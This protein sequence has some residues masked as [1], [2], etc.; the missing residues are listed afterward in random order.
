MPVGPRPRKHEIAVH[1]GTQSHGSAPPPEAPF[2]VVLLGDFSGRANRGV[3]EVGA[4]LGQRRIVQVDRDTLDDVLAKLAPELRLTL[5]D[6]SGAPMALRFR[7]LDDF[8]PDRLYDTVPLFQA[9]RRARARVADADAFA[10]ATRS[11]RRAARPDDAGTAVSA[12]TAREVL[13]APGALLDKILDVSA[14]GRGDDRTVEPD[15][16]Q[17]LVRRLVAPHVVPG[18]DPRQAEWLERV[19]AAIGAQMRSILHHPD[20]Q[21]L[22]ALWRAVD[23]LT[24]RIETS[25][26]LGLYVIDVSRAEVAADLGS[27][28]PLEATGLYRLLV[29]RSV[30]TAGGRPWAVVV[31]AYA[32]GPGS[33]D[34]QLLGALAAL[35]RAAGAPWI[36][37]AADGLAGCDSLQATP[38]PA[39]W[40]GDVDPA[41]DAL[42]RSPNAMWLGLMLPR[43]LLRLPYGADT[44][45]CDAIAF[46]E[47]AG[48]PDP[49]Q[50]LWGNPAVAA[51]LL[52]S[53]AFATAGW[54][55]RPG[56]GLDISHLPLHVVR[57]DGEVVAQPCAEVLL[58]ERAAQRLLD[59]GLM[60]LAS[61]KDTDRARLV[62]FQSV[63]SP[64]AAL[65][66]RW[67]PA[68]PES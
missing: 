17:A 45:P 28:Q 13:G 32:F 39:D 47:F 66:G 30:G 2:S 42:R 27:G 41:F 35:A 1:V 33:E 8:H 19:D 5:P 40:T 65:A 59:R 10:E 34:A 15:A 12:E 26:E 64:I 63:A 37:A 60:P 3:L 9:L 51:A 67:N 14:E 11:L 20:V 46:E 62:R 61:V 4:D 56:A 29:E 57:R 21:A 58:T 23:L 53:Q 48:A 31:G 18:V 24:R 68:P 7:A 49:A 52:L 43:F 16:L 6:Q 50:Y 54:A 22:E 36:S 55:R 25:A 44:E 38:D